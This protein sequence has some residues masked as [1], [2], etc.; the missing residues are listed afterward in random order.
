VREEELDGGHQRTH[1]VG[2]MLLFFEQQVLGQL[3]FAEPI[4]REGE[5]FC[6]LSDVAQ[7]GPGG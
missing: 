6:E 3:I 7:V 4:G 5:V 2:F 1:R